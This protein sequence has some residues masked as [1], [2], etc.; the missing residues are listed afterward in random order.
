MRSKTVSSYVPL[1]ALAVVF[2]FL[3]LGSLLLGNKALTY[4]EPQHFKYGEQIYELNSDRFDDSKMPISVLNVLPSRL[5]ARIVGDRLASIWQIMSIGRISTIVFSL[6]LG[7]LCFVWA[8]SMYGALVGLV[9]FGL[10]VLEPNIVAHSRLITTD[11]FAAGTIT[12]TLFLFWRFLESPSLGR[13]ALAALALGLAQI[14]KYTGL[15]LYPI[16][17]LLT[18]IRHWPWIASRLRSRAYG[19]LWHDLIV[20]V[21]YGLV[22]AV[23]SIVVINLGFLFN[24]TFASFGSFSFRS[25]ELRLIQSRSGL[26]AA[27]PVPVPYPYLEGLDWVLFH[28]RTGIGYGNVY[29]LGA[30]KEAEGFPGYFLV[31]SLFKVPLPLLVLFGVSFVD[32]LRGFRADEFRSREMYLLVPALVFAI[33]FNLFFRT[34]IGIRFF[35][36]VFPILLIFSSRI[37]VKWESFSRRAQYAFA[38]SGLFLV[39]SVASYFPHYLSYFNELVPDRKQAY[40]ILSDSNI[41]WG[42]NRAEL[43]EFLSTHAGYTFEPEDPTPGLVIVGVNALTGVLED[44]STFKWLREN[45]SPVG[46]L[47]YTY[48]IYDISPSDLP[49]D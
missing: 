2:L 35:L 47:D 29:L 17:I 42:Q 8:K 6:G 38:F 25:N 14:A 23:L 48:L 11:I 20:F 43:S 4:D 1:L 39:V 18:V 27:L 26:M 24:D 46:Q 15:L 49:L 12:L 34:H 40:R 7:L 28:E 32:W 19:N 33:Y 44:P 37:F 9:T 30:L 31:A 5:A 13:A 16:L 10:Y 41:D 3:T 22:F 45:F 21:G 36:I